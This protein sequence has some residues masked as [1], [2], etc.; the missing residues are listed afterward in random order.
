MVKRVT[1]LKELEVQK[2]ICYQNF[3]TYA[4]KQLILSPSGTQNLLKSK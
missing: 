4:Y 2:G 1:I 3:I